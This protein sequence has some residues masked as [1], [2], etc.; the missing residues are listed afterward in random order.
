MIVTRFKDF[1]FNSF[2]DV[3][4]NLWHILLAPYCLVYFPWRFTCT[5][6]TELAGF[7][8]FGFNEL[9]FDLKNF[10]AS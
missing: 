2:I 7:N 10:L 4:V 9:V 5:L 6:Y 3:R 1:L 8:E